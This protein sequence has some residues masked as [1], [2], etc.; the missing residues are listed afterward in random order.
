MDSFVLFETSIQFFI[1][2][3]WSEWTSPFRLGECSQQ[4]WIGHN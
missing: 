1:E 2:F 4:Y 3:D